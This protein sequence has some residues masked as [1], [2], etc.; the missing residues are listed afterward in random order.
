MIT[1]EEEG[2]EDKEGGERGRRSGGKGSTICLFV[3]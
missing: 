3:D 2:E 1:G